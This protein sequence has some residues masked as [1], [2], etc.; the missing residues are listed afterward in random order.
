M[1][2]DAYGLA[3]QGGFD[4]T[5]R[6][7]LARGA[8]SERARE[9]AQ[10]AWSRGW[11]RLEQLRDERFVL[12]WVNAI[13]LN[14]YRNV[15]RSEMAYQ[16]LPK[17]YSNPNVNVA[18][19]DVA[20]ILKICR[21]DDRRLLEQQLSGASVE[22]IATKR[23]ETA[24]AVRLRLHRA[25]RAAR[26]GIELSTDRRLRGTPRGSLGRFLRHELANSVL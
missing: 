19:I 25:R 22:E 13:A 15:L 2:R 9:V 18:A 1:T 12:T 6:L 20:R 26:K 5:V 7:L 14:L 3:F 23:G 21:P 16:A 10:S 17:L 11:E 4:S 24:A 8:F